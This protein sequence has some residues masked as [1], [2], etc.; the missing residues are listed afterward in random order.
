SL[1]GPETISTSPNVTTAVAQQRVEQATSSWMLWLAG[2]GVAI[3]LALLLFGRSLR[4]RFGSASVALDSE[5]PIRE[6]PPRPALWFRDDVDYNLD[7]DTPTAENPA[8]DADLVM[9]T[10]LNRTS[11]VDMAKDVGFPSPTEV[12]IELPFSAELAAVLDDDD[13]RSA[14]LSADS[15]IL[16]SEILPES[17]DYPGPE[18]FDMSVILDATKM[19]RAE[20]ATQSNLEAIEMNAP[21]ETMAG[22]EADDEVTAESTIDL[23]IL[24]QDYENEKTA[25]QARN[26]D[27]TQAALILAGEMGVDNGQAESD[28]AGFD[29]DETI[30]MARAEV[31]DDDV[32][33]Q[34][35]ADTGEVIVLDEGD[36][37]VSF[38][39]E[40]TI[41]LSDDE[42]TVDMPTVDEDKT[43]KMPARPVAKSKKA[44]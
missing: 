6:A 1:V 7:D 11:E 2:S 33:T 24:E 15:T 9:G 10:G 41:H 18:D 40:F 22:I 3:I 43:R 28:G 42:K 39:D 34:L 27:V 25:I 31:A 17:D 5:L 29:D 35:E 36:E 20:D 4:G 32:R 16:E 12:D 37:D 26:M 30:A 21:T 23:T 14:T 44:G 13:L 8:L 38:D 19:P